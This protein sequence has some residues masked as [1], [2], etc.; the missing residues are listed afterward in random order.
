ME[1]DVRSLTYEGLE[2]AY[3]AHGDTGPRILSVPNWIT[4]VEMSD[5]PFAVPGVG[6]RLA[7][8]CRLAAFDFPGTGSSDPIPL[9][10]VP[11]LEFWVGLVGVVLDKLEWERATL[12]ACDA[13]GLVALAFAAGHPDR[14]TSL[15]LA[16]A[17]AAYYPE[18]VPEVRDQVADAFA[19][20]YGRPD[21][22]RLLSP[23]VD[24]QPGRAGDQARWLRQA[25]RPAVM[26][27]IVRM[28]LDV[29]VRDRLSD[30][31][32]PV[33]LIH[34]ATNFLT[35][36][37][38]VAYLHD[39]LPDATFVEFP[40]NDMTPIRPEDTERWLTEIRRFL[41]GEADPVQLDRVLSTVMFTDIVASTSHTTQIGDHRWR[42]VLDRHDA[43]AGEIVGR[44]GG[45]L[46]KSTG[47]GILATIDGPARA[48]RCAQEFSFAMHRIGLEIRVGLHTGEVEL[49]GDDIG[50]IAVT[51]ARRVCDS[52]GPNEVRVSETLVGVVAGS[53]LSFDDVGAIEPKGVPGT[54]RLYRARD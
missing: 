18:A 38:R 20:M 45:R 39:H 11:Q 40:G 9:D 16:N 7:S 49:R 33:L 31:R 44:F 41:L 30:V 10:A 28:I 52:A 27:P 12:F 26:R 37:D 8:S 24:V 21:Y 29:D 15:I 35:D 46:I 34:S 48:V 14:V 22:V 50:G 53:G 17:T 47:D 1:W 19:Q 5:V 4:N 6:R 2:V 13:G 3:A 43:L 36:R 23:S 32:C 25:A 54:W 42:E 51:I